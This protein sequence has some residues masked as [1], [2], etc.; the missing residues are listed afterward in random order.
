V[1]RKLPVYVGALL[2]FFFTLA[3]AYWLF[4][5]AISYNQ[6]LT[7]SPPQWFPTN[8][9]YD[10]LIALITGGK[11][12]GAGIGE[13]TSPSAV[14]QRAV[15]NS[16]TVAIVTTSICLFMG[17][18]TAYAFTRLR[19]PLKGS[20]LLLAITAQMVPPIVLVIPLYQVIRTLGL[21]D[22]LA[23]LIILYSSFILVY[24]I[25]VMTGFFRTI[26]T[27]LEESALIDGCTRLGA[28]FRVILPL[29]LPGLFATGLLCFLMSWDEF[30][31]ALIFTSSAQA[32][33]ITVAIGE[34]TKQYTI[35]YG[36]MMAG[37]FVAS[38][39][40]LILALVFQRSLVKG[41]TA[42]AVKG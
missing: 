4:V 32:K 36:M 24:V 34:F 41:L 35:D 40:P 11:V 7:Q 20:L 8:P 38:I 21:M 31:F 33:T 22:T 18:L 2:V 13:S 16:F 17:S 5:S 1:W 28:L 14:F 30:M 6:D 26:P 39:P 3:P 12:E 15:F 19:F 10:R 29:S 37:G 9:T 27:E 25:W 42:G 23:A